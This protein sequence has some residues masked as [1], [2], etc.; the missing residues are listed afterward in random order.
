[1]QFDFN[2]LLTKSFIYKG[3]FKDTIASISNFI[4]GKK[5][6]SFLANDT[7]VSL[8]Y[9][10]QTMDNVA[11]YLTEETIKTANFT[12]YNFVVISLS[13]KTYKEHLVRQIATTK[14]R[15]KTKIESLKAERENVLKNNTLDVRT[16]KMINSIHEYCDVVLDLKKYTP[17]EEKSDDVLKTMNRI[18]EYWSSVQEAKY[19]KHLSPFVETVKNLRK[20]LE[21]LKIQSNLHCL[22]HIT[23]V[24]VTI[25]QNNVSN[26]SIFIYKKNDDLREEY[27]NH[28]Y[29]KAKAYK[30]S[31][32]VNGI[33]DTFSLLFDAI[34][35]N[36][37]LLGKNKNDIPVF[38]TDNDTEIKRAIYGKLSFSK[39]YFEN[40]WLK[41]YSTFEEQFKIIKTYFSLMSTNLF[42]YRDVSFMVQ[43]DLVKKQVNAP[44]RYFSLDSRSPFFVN[45]NLSDFDNFFCRSNCTVLLS[46]SYAF[47]D[48]AY[49]NSSDCEKFNK[50]G[51]FFNKIVNNHRHRFGFGIDVSTIFTSAVYSSMFTMSQFIIRNK[52]QQLNKYNNHLQR[53][54]KAHHFS[55][56]YQKNICV[57]S[58]HGPFLKRETDNVAKIVFKK[59]NLKEQENDTDLFVKN[60][61]QE[62]NLSNGKIFPLAQA[63][64]A[65]ATLVALI[66]S[67]SIGPGNIVSISITALVS[68]ILLVIAVIWLWK[69]GKK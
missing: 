42:L 33:L 57:Y 52:I 12:D 62:S 48:T 55:T 63:L 60:M 9:K 8:F 38:V 30:N 17:R 2:C 4:A 51:W 58:S 20:Y 53:L 40:Y 3:S 10:K 68:T 67:F 23:G 11:C 41:D 39:Q 44:C 45:N 26:L 1:M 66:I 56:M 18:S 22:N 28:E 14:E 47:H 7:P 21:F 59:N 35:L 6:G 54:F 49:L 61:W 50:D 34:D 25:G 13:A 15:Y 24:A 43:T 27:S 65:I 29:W 31:N 69:S 19:S 37:V 64:A 16:R 46:S 32:E 5:P 36:D